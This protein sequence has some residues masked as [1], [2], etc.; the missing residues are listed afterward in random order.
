MSDSVQLL[1]LLAQSEPQ[2]HQKK[3]LL[4]GRVQPVE[5]QKRLSYQQLRFYSLQDLEWQWVGV[6]PVHLLIEIFGLR[7]LTNVLARRH[8]VFS[9]ILPP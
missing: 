7:Q 8:E 6:L 5:S 2:N 9:Q 3:M 4:I 1:V